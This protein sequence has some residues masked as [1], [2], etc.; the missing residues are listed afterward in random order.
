MELIPAIDIIEGKCVRLSQGDFS[1]Q[2]TYSASPLDMAKRFQDAG[3]R[4]LHL[5]DLD[6]ARTGKVVNWA[7]AEQI[8]K[9]TDMQIDFGGGV[10]SRE[11]VK[12]ILELGISYVVVG[13]VAVKN[14][15]LL[16]EWKEEFGP[17]SFFIGADVKDGL[18]H[19]SG[20]QE[21]TKLQIGTLL[22]ECIQQ[23]FN[24]FFCT[25]IERDGLFKGPSVGLYEQLLEEF[26]SI[27][28]VSSGGVSSIKDLYLLEKIGCVGAIVG[29]AIYEGMITMDEVQLF[30]TKRN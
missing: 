21:T 16:L 23:G 26:P 17:D 22:R 3:V 11:D 29:K 15:P 10:K 18:I 19:I 28:L 14:K 20:W 1:Q 12:R 8:A 30:C 13:S 9:H 27:E 25:D 4:R 5:V 24:H 7:T 6:G 2:S